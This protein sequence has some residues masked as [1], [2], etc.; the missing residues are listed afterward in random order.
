MY[1]G[2]SS[3]A[4]EEWVRDHTYSEADT[5]PG[6]GADGRAEP[7][8]GRPYSSAFQSAPAQLSG[9]YYRHACQIAQPRKNAQG[10][11]RSG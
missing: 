8:G 5:R 4:D 2:R 10:R 3:E 7:P 11:T 6:P 9:R 1:F